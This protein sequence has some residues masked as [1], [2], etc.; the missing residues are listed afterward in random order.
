M[1]T[2]SLVALSFFAVLSAS[3]SQPL[4]RAVQLPLADGT[5][6]T[7]ERRGGPEMSWWESTDGHRYNYSDAHQLVPFTASDEARLRE[8]SLGGYLPF[9][10]TTQGARRPGLHH[11][12]VASTPDGLGAFGV[13]GEGVIKSIGTPTIPVI[14]VAFA[15]LDFLPANDKSKIDRFLNEE[16]YKDESYAVGSVA[17]YFEHSS[18]G[19]FKP[20]FE[21]VAKVTLSNGY[22]YYGAKSGSATD[23]RRSEAIREAVKLAEAQGVDFSKYSTGG[24]SPLISVL[25]AGPGEQ[26]DFG[27]DY[28][29]YFWAHFSQTSITG[30]TATFD[31]YLLTNETMRDFDSAGNLTA[32]YMTGIGTFCHELGHALGLP[33]MY[34]V[35]GKTDGEGQT[36]GYWDVMDY[37]FMYNGFRPM[38]YSAY[39][40][41]MMGWLNVKNITKSG[42]ST[43]YDLAPLGNAREGENEAFRIVNPSNEKEYFLLENRQKSTFY[44]DN[45]LGS[46]M[47]V[48]RINY[49]SN[50]WSGNRV[51]VNA[52][53]QRV[54]VVPADGAWQSNADLN[55]RDAENKRYTF[56]G[57]L[58]PG[59]ANV[60][61]FNAELCN[62]ES[63]SFEGS[64]CNIGVLAENEHVTFNYADPTLITGVEAFGAQHY[65]PMYDLQGRRVQSNELPAGMYIQGGRIVIRK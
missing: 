47:L 48:W 11:S 17:D 19:H 1:K 18:N 26:E 3:A 4:R 10:A 23:A 37:Q 16:G 5:M 13:S 22:K 49:D 41:S 21:V 60:T 36:P 39:E 57:D 6:I 33:D 53:H 38:E 9:T 24:H 15:D 43:V 25:H 64:V 35:N 56:V 62:F 51:N 50:L 34:D 14:M 58:F 65:T 8:V 20:H 54:S 7:V 42:G 44:M 12:M 27:N 2:K 63:G 46:G 30:S 29:D 28:Q 32:E 31:S 52:N 59:Y 61:S 45:M 55:L 40:R